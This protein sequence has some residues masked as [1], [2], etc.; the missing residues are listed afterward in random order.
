MPEY[1]VLADAGHAACHQLASQSERL[2]HLLV[3]HKDSQSGLLACLDDLLG[4]VYNLFFATHYGYSDRQNALT[5]HD[6]SN[7]AIRANDMAQ[8]K[9]RIDGK[10]AAGVFFN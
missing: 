7:V 2:G 9:V 6:M 1:L 10:W 4:A 8:C 5:E 3:K